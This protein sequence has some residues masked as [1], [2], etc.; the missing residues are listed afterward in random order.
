MNF[1]S[2]GIILTNAC[3]VMAVVTVTH[4]RDFGPYRMIFMTMRV[5]CFTF[6]RHS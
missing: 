5:Y 3:A 4:I 2:Y 6:S 1:G